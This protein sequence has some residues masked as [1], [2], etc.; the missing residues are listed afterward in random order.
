M[1]WDAMRCN[2]MGWE[3]RVEGVPRTHEALQERQVARTNVFKE[4]LMQVCWRP[5]GPLM[6]AYAQNECDDD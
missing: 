6:R 2:E 1:G 4:E 3:G 5:D